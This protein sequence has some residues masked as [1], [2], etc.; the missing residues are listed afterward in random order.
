MGG[1][2]RLYRQLRENLGLVYN[3]NT[4][5]ACYEDVGFLGIR[6]VCAPENVDEVRIK[7]INE[8]DSLQQN[9]IEATELAAVK[10]NYAGTLARRFETNL[11]V[12]G[13][14][15]IEALLSSI[16]TFK[17]AVERINLVTADNILTAAQQYLSTS[18]FVSSTL[19]PSD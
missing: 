9:W 17:Q 15:G 11:S 12:A 4:V 1:S 14:F 6:A 16:E 18:C 8:W 10:G 13:I 7:I 3:I 2:G 19:G 5:S